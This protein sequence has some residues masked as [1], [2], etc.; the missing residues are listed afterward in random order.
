MA[1]D[2]SLAGG[3]AVILRKCFELTHAQTADD[4]A[5]RKHA[6]KLLEKSG[7][8][9]RQGNQ[10]QTSGTVTV[11]AVPVPGSPTSGFGPK[12]N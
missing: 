12:S 10:D 7:S 4:A 2:V 8:K 5:L 6:E 1:D 3:I 11:G 9:S